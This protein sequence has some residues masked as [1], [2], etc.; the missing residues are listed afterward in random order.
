M[1]LSNRW[2][3]FLKEHTVFLLLFL[4]GVLLRILFLNSQGLSHDELSAWNRI[5]T[6]NFAE[7]LEYGVKPDM[8]PALMQVVL[9]YWVSWFGDDAWV[10]RL[11]S[12]F[13]GLAAIAL[14]YVFANRF[15][16]KSAGIFAAVFFLFL[17]FPI[18]HTVLARPY[19]LGLFFI[20][21]MIYSIF[22]LEDSRTR[23]QYFLNSILLILGTTGALYTH[24]FAGL[25]AGIIGLASLI[26]VLRVRWIFL[27]PS[28]VISVFL[29]LPHWKITKVHLSRDGLEWL[30]KPSADWILDFF[31]LFFNNSIFLL[32]IFVLVIGLFLLNSRFKLTHRSRFLLALFAAIYIVGHALSLIYTPILR[33]PGVLMALPILMLGLGDLIQNMSSRFSHLVIFALAFLFSFHSVYESKLSETVHYEPFREMVQ[34]IQEA[35][36]LYGEENILKLCNVTNT[37]YLNYY[38]REIDV[39]LDFE[40]TLIEEI[41]EIHQLARIVRESDK[42]YC[43]LAR[44]N[45]SQNVIQLEIIRY[46]FPVVVKHVGFFNANFTIWRRGERKAR[47]F[48]R[49]ITPKTQ[50]D[51]YT[52]W[53]SDTSDNEF[54]G[55]LRIPVAM[56][57]SNDSYVL[58]LADGWVVND[59]ESL[60]FVVVAERNEE[61]ILNDDI[62]ILYQAWDQMKL[63]QISGKRQFFTA[64]EVPKEIKDSDVLHVYFWNRNFA[65]IKI[66]KPRAYVIQTTH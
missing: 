52:S 41:D 15:L 59:L 48:G 18:M 17:V 6:Y 21:L 24:Y 50:P 42:H 40:M 3:I 29:F 19:A 9:Q 2:Q 47:K 16:S 51:L 43:I 32:A 1:T 28:G 7:V 4:L 49:E 55:D 25:I 5:G 64:V 53:N 14:M 13:F 57:K 34:L 44:T 60:N 38:A 37:N 62:P 61:M 23:K 39:S 8:H 65:K 35:D 56:L 46:Y 27:I 58:I 36:N 10:L 12:T 26:Y 11:P 45:R 33:E 22:S 63:I 31:V 20:V 66:E 30:G 54:I